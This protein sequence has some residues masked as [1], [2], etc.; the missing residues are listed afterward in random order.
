MENQDKNKDL[1]KKL[2]ELKSK[3][4]DPKLVKAIQDKQSKVGK[5][6]NK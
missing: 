6:F 3:T 2:E 5:P 1:C 4:K